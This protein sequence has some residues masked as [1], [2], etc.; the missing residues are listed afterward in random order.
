MPA[1][2]QQSGSGR[3]G[4]LTE[5]DPLDIALR[6]AS[7]YRPSAKTQAS[8]Q[9]FPG[10][11][12]FRDKSREFEEGEDEGEPF[13]RSRR[14]VAVRRGLLPPGRW[15]RIGFAAGTIA[16][17][18]GLVG[19]GVAT[20]DFAAHDPRFRI[21]SSENVQVLGNSQVT[22]SELLSVFG[23]D[24][25]RNVFFIPLKER[26]ADLERLPWVET[27]TVM[28]LLPDQLRVSVI[29][30]TPV[31]FVRIGNEIGLVDHDGVLLPM[32]PK[33]MA[34]KHYSFPV[35]TGIAA[36]DALSTRIARMKLYQRLLSELDSA[37][38]KLS[39]QLSEVDLSDPEDVK[40]LVP[41]EGN[42]LLLHLGD[43]DFLSRWRNYQQ[44]LTEWKTQYPRLASV[45]LRYERQVVLEMQKGATVPQNQGAP[46]R[47]M[48]DLKAEASLTSPTAARQM[49]AAN[50]KAVI[51]SSSKQAVAPRR[52]ASSSTQQG[53][54]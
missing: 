27:A 44:H 53:R 47:T 21:D 33:T 49:A 40:A 36:A 23:G 20:R 28:R 9:T 11:S 6:E 18:A 50:R 42:D 13:L 12:P 32:D 37:G 19:L 39:S 45:D 15:G 35:I 51:K 4:S 48:D 54:N 1:R 8:N 43:R 31:A 26:R 25:G 16:V 41:S 38:E 29:E 30:R 5:D 3:G 10:G 14:R 24:M 52:W 34:G 46:G 7:F 17:I 22:Q 2:S